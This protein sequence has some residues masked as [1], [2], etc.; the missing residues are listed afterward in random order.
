M[1]IRAIDLFCGAGGLTCGLQ[2]AG[3]KVAAGIDND[4]S[5]KYAYEHNNKAVFICNDISNISEKELN[6]YYK[7]N[8]IKLLAGCAPCQP[9]SK[10]Q[11]DKTRKDKNSKW[12][13]L[14]Q[15]LNKVEEINPDIVSME[16]VSELE[17][18]VVFQDFLS[19]LKKLGYHVSYKILNAADYGVPQRRKRLLLL[20]SKF[21]KIELIE[22]THINKH[23]TLRKA[24]GDLPYIKA[25]ETCTTDSLHRSAN[26]NDINIK[27][28]R[29]SLQGGTWE[30]WPKDLVPECYKKDS[31]KTFSS[32]YG[33]ATYDKI[34]PTLTTQFIRYGTGRYGHPTQ[35]RAFS[36][37]E[38]AIIQTF[39]ADYQF[40]KP[41]E[42]ATIAV[43]SRQ[44]GNAV[45]VR[46]GEVIGKSIKK[47]IKALGITKHE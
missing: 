42:K 37:R 20:A 27:R 6:K 11:K 26:L 23:I 46:L 24:I 18:E 9:F 21:G 8:D 36:L 12:G 14:Y 40:V 32:V 15:F 17:K 33:R 25:G 45:P 2:K 30:D 34:S 39:P 28:I 44:I 3:I 16:N 22:P 35:D 5:C 13:L 43:I 10:Y 1:V 47:H 4:E 19:G 29:N 38:G 41:G 7:K 31:G